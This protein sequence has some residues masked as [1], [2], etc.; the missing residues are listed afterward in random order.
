MKQSRLVSAIEA[1]VNTSSGFLLAMAIWQFVVPVFYPHLT[2]TVDEN[3]FMTTV[4]TTVSMTRGYLWR[5][6]FNNELHSRLV[7]WV[8]IGD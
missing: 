5:R 6:F 4:F 8:R 7:R 3:I 1:V 2:P